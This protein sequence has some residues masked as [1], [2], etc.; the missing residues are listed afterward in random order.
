[1]CIWFRHQRPA[2]WMTALGGFLQLMI[3]WFC[4]AVSSPSTPPTS[5]S[6]PAPYMKQSRKH[7]DEPTGLTGN[8]FCGGGRL[9]KERAATFKR[10]D[11]WASFLC[12]V[13][14]AFHSTFPASFWHIGWNFFSVY[15]LDFRR[16][17]KAAQM[18]VWSLDWRAGNSVAKN[19]GYC[20]TC[21]YVNAKC[22][23]EILFLSSPSL[24]WTTRKRG[25][26]KRHLKHLELCANGDATIL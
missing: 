21:A 17:M 15:A 16:E 13:V 23:S 4:T 6:M 19:R 18:T 20:S 26:P 24:L 1:M 14:L 10:R 3:T 22:A 25:R 9:I 2:N 7:M 12:S 5:R 11:P 8:F